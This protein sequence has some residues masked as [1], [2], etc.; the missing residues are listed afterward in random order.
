MAQPPLVQESP[1][2][3]DIAEAF[4]ADRV[5]FWNRFGSFIIFGV[6]AVIIL[7]IGLWLFVA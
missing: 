5:M 7:V 2:G 1:A 4:I 3:P 6:V